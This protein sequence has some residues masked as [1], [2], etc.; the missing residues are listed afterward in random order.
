MLR[1][2]VKP[3]EYFDKWVSYDLEQIARIQS[4]IDSPNLL[5]PY[6]RVLAASHIC[7][8]SLSVVIMRYSAGFDLG[9]LR[10]DMLVFLQKREQLRAMCEALPPEL[11]KN[12]AM[13]E[14]LSFDNYIDHFW[15]L[16][17]AFCLGME[18]SYIVRTLVLIG[19]SGK[20]ALL[21]RIALKLG[22][23]RPVTAAQLL[24]PKQYAGL[25]QAIDATAEEQARLLKQFLD[26]WYKG[27]RNVAAWYDRHQHDDT[28]YVGYWCFEAA[29]VVK[30][31][32][33]DDSEC[34]THPHY[35]EDLVHAR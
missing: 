14:R 20:D 13:Y 26:G 29:L 33:L 1:D 30:L 18:R 2:K 31:F 11:Q 9:S 8:K 21:D 23:E 7:E 6:G 17:L 28:G 35:P 3:S 4:E 5:A 16:S 24:F 34:R 10:G 22:D 32:G 15:W 12:R 25:F 19:N 27:N